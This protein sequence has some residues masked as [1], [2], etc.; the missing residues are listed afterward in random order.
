MKVAKGN[1]MGKPHVSSK[2]A[3][4]LKMQGQVIQLKVSLIESDPLIWRRIV[5]PANMTLAKLHGVLQMVMGW[6]NSHLSRFE[7]NNEP[8]CND[9]REFDD[10]PET[11]P[12]TTKLG[13]IVEQAKTFLYIYDYGDNWQHEITVES[14]SKV[15]EA[16]QYP[17]CIGGENA[18]PPE[19]CGA[20]SGYYEKLEE[21]FDKDHPE[22][23]S[24]KMWLGGYFDPKTFDPNRINRDMLWM[25][26][27]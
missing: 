23:E 5:V 22:H 26:K 11:K 24:T 18:C 8:Y 12:L 14:I 16:M 1:F 17:V 10:E 27:W 15:E 2:K 20:L 4:M 9:E 21:Y 7:I 25:K 6:Q 3:S 19:D 13:D